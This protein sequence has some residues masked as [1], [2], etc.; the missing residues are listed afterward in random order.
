MTLK[1]LSAVVA[2][3]AAFTLFACGPSDNTSNE[4]YTLTKMTAMADGFQTFSESELAS[5]S[6]NR[7]ASDSRYVFQSL[8]GGTLPIEFT[9]VDSAGKSVSVTPPDIENIRDINDRYAA[10]NMN[11]LD[12]SIDGTEYSGTYTVIYDKTDGKLYPLTENNEP[13]D[14]KV[15][16]E[17]EF[18]YTSTRFAN[19]GDDDRLYMRHSEDKSLYVATRHDSY[20]EVNRIFG[21]YQSTPFADKNGDI[22]RRETDNT[23]TWVSAEDFSKTEL[24]SDIDVSPMLINDELYG[25][26]GT[27]IYKL[28][29]SGSELLTEATAWTATASYNTWGMRARRGDYEMTDYCA[30]YEFDHVTQAI[31]E[32][33]PAVTG[34][35]G[36]RAVA[37]GDDVLFCTYASSDDDTPKF[38]AFNTTDESITDF[39]STE[40]NGTSLN[41]GERFT[42]ISDQ[43][44]MFY[45]YPSNDF[46]EFY[47][48]TNGSEHQKANTT[49]SVSVIMHLK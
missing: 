24:T 8:S 19:I 15:D 28:S 29:R 17:H 5:R 12:L 21:D 7:N 20:F 45:E 48:K 31:I 46:T 22:L 32:V 37:A 27:S 26:S 18:W 4:T 1:H 9:A 49:G 25:L 6:L 23:Y 33:E 30:V 39:A 44:I 13:L 11:D 10:I 47:I 16:A 40:G 3:V 34:S 14:Y 35:A 41:A 42:V 36:R 2:P 38:R 43:E